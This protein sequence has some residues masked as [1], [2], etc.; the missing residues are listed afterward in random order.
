EL[1]LLHRDRDRLRVLATLRDDVEGGGERVRRE[2]LGQLRTALLHD[3]E[4]SRFRDERDATGLDALI[5]LEGNPELVDLLR[6]RLVGDEHVDGGLGLLGVG[7]AF[8]SSAWHHETSHVPSPMNTP[9]RNIPIRTESA[10]ATVLETF[11]PIE[12]GA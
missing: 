7:P 4:R 6:R 10:E 2:I 9:T 12:R 8:S 5:G 11:A 1:G 3:R